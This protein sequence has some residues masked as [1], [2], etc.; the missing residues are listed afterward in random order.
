MLEVEFKW[1]RAN[2]AGWA[3]AA[4]VTYCRW[5]SRRW[6]LHSTPP[7]PWCWLWLGQCT[8]PWGLGCS[9]AP[10]SGSLAPW[11]SADHLFSAWTSSQLRHRFR[12]LRSEILVA[13]SNSELSGSLAGDWDLLEEGVLE[14]HQKMVIFIL[15][16]SNG[17]S[18]GHL[19]RQ[20]WLL[21][22]HKIPTSY[23]KPQASNHDPSPPN[24]RVNFCS[25]FYKY[26]G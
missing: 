19:Q 4:P 18:R 23:Q 7:G 17:S 26:F 9:A 24:T 10:R 20:Y 22:L 21:E 3:G 1:Q 5:G 2:V 13:R 16:R 6:D 15:E 25:N 8:A 14:N 11:C 12:L